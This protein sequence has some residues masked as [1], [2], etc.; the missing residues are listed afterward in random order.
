MLKNILICKKSLFYGKYL[1]IEIR[2]INKYYIFCLDNKY[3]IKKIP[4]YRNITYC[5]LTV[6]HFSRYKY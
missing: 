3:Y 6:Q 5:K 2:S 1:R 4:K